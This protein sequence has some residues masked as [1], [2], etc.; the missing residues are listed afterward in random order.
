MSFYVFARGGVWTKRHTG[1]VGDSIAELP[2]AYGANIMASFACDL[3]GG[4]KGL[5][6]KGDSVA[7]LDEVFPASRAH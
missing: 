5:C 3:H 7:P 4:K 2:K 1:I 6:H